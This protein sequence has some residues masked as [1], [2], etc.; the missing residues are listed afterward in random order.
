M[1]KDMS[2]GEITFIYIVW[3]ISALVFTFGIFN[4]FGIGKDA[5][6]S[7]LP[8]SVVQD[9][10]ADSPLNDVIDTAKDT[11]LSQV[12]GDTSKILLGVIAYIVLA[13]LIFILVGKAK[14][15]VWGIYFFGI[16]LHLLVGIVLIV[17]TLNLFQA[18]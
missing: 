5:I 16:V 13:T 6:D 3:L 11:V 17:T 14:N 7:V 18:P 1:W 15:R 8:A 4:L 12:G 10:G 9:A 2:K